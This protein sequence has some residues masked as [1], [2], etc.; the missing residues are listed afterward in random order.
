MLT[1]VC[2]SQLASCIAT[3]QAHRSCRLAHSPPM[4]L[5]ITVKCK[6]SHAGAATPKPSSLQGLLTPPSPARAV[7]T[8][9]RSV[10]LGTV[11]RSAPTPF[12][13]TFLAS[14]LSEQVGKWSTTG[15]PQGFG[16]HLAAQTTSQTRLCHCA[17]VLAMLCKFVLC[18]ACLIVASHLHHHFH[19]GV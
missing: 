2:C 17:N 4:L 1:H 3:M 19:Q 11:S 9:P 8:Q 6:G 14:Q 16:T 7:T 13:S 5:L 12:C 10:H 15:Q 18:C